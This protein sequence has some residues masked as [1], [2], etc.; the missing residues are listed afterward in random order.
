M[1]QKNSFFYV[2]Q[3]EK[4]TG[5]LQGCWHLSSTVWNALTE[6]SYRSRW[7]S[8]EAER[9][10]SLKDLGAFPSTTKQT[11]TSSA[12]ELYMVVH[13]YNPSM[14]KARAG[15]LW[16]WGQPELHSETLSQNKKKKIALP[17]NLRLN[18]QWIYDDW[19]RGV[20]L[21]IRLSKQVNEKPSNIPMHGV[22]DY[23]SRK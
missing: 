18:S 21:I 11:K 12:V 3:W 23:R 2:G 4:F 1:G 7:C 13:T 15:E 9:S 6:H 14:W 20:T 19:F 10:P 5:I 17:T 22:L 16:V 8:S